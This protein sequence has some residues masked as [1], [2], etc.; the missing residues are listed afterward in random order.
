MIRQLALFILLTS[1]SVTASAQTFFTDNF[2]DGNYDGWSVTVPGPGGATFDATDGSFYMANSA[3]PFATQ[4]VVLDVSDDPAFSAGVFSV[5]VTPDNADTFAGG[6]FRRTH[7]DGTS[8]GYLFALALNP[9]G[10]RGAVLTRFDDDLPFTM[11]ATLDIDENIWVP[12]ETYRLSAAFNGPEF[13]LTVTD[14][15]GGASWSAV[16]ED[17]IYPVGQLEL[18]MSKSFFGG[19]GPVGARFDNVTFEA[20]PEPSSLTCGL[21]GCAALFGLR[22]RIR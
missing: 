1:L 12:G 2:D 6:T 11:P 22:R 15:S 21:L 13:T 7:T 16:G 4:S 10:N 9:W 17:S 19:P 3:D 18:L 20:I 14:L 8:D 5:D